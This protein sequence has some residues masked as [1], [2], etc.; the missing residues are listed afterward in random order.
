MSFVIVNIE[1]GKAY[2]KKSYA[3]DVYD[4]ERGAKGMCTRL[5]T[6][7]AGIDPS[8]GMKLKLY[9]EQWKVITSAEYNARPVKMV[10]RINLMSGQPYMEAEDTPRSCSPASE[11]YWAS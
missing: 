4:T 7:A 6:K 9:D 3:R 1:T 5:N 2:G 8:T 10:E 11:L